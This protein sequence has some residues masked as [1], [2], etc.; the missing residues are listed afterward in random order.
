MQMCTYNWEDTA[1]LLTEFWNLN[2]RI[3]IKS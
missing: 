2:N 1:V 3:E